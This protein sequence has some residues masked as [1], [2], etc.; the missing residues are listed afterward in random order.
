MQKL[1][2][3]L[4]AF[5]DRHDGVHFFNSLKSFTGTYAGFVGLNMFQ[6]GYT[7][8]NFV[9]IW[10]V[11]WIVVFIMIN[12]FTVFLRVSDGFLPTLMC[13]TTLGM[14]FQGLGKVYL[15]G[16]NCIDLAQQ[17]QAGLEFYGAIRHPKGKIVARDYAF[18]FW[19][20]YVY[21]M[22]IAYILAV[23][24]GLGFPV[25]YNYFTV[26]EFI[27]P[28]DIKLPFVSTTGNGFVIHFVYI[29]VC[30]I[31][32]FVGTLC[33]DSFY[34][35]L[36]LNALTQLE[37][38]FVEL[39]VL[40]ET[41]AS[42]DKAKRVMKVSQQLKDIIKLHQDYLEYITFIIDKFE[43]YFTSNVVTLVFQIVLCCYI[44]FVDVSFSPSELFPKLI[45]ENC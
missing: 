3:R 22:H 4:L 33:G 34:S 21:V 9:F 15:Y 35:I 23:V 2:H 41:I 26:G 8:K 29:I 40:N 1:I 12:L 27:L 17:I 32:E 42:G 28:V 30:G 14:A 13:A 7:N 16:I 31:L 24:I 25:V 5:R 45:N 20:L 10:S 44:D 39:G 36:L 37:N 38:L 6:A 43:M 18:G 11:S 19:I